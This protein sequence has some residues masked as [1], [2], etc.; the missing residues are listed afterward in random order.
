VWTLEG[1]ARE[2]ADLQP[3]FPDGRPEIILHL[4]DPFD[5]IGLAGAGERQPATIFAG[6]LIGPLTLRPTGSIAVVGIRLQPHGAAAVLEV[7]QDD[8]VGRTIGV[9][10]LSPRLARALGEVGGRTT[11]VRVAADLVRRCLESC[12]DDSRVDR[13]VGL[14]VGYINAVRGRVTVDH[15]ARQVGLTPRHLERRFKNEVGISPKR[16]ARITRFQ[17]ALR[18]LDR[19]DSP[20]RGT[21][22]AAECGYADQA[23]FIRDF[24][25]MAGCPPGAHLL[26]QAELNGFFGASFVD[27]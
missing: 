24:R 26:R 22:T 1:H 5:R 20:Q 12:V 9:D 15:L 7:P 13:R 21:H 25:E 6:Q 19:L 8:L 17:C 27:L 16:L 23:H 10:D 18:L 4:G 11:S 14:A 3:I 2:C